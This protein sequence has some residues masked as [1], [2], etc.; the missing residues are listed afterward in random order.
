MSISEDGYGLASTMS[1]RHDLDDLSSFIETDLTLP[2]RPLER[3]GPVVDNQV[4]SNCDI[5]AYDGCDDLEDS[6]G[7]VETDLTFSC[8]PLEHLGPVDEDHIVSNCGIGAPYDR[9]GFANTASPLHDGLNFMQRLLQELRDPNLDCTPESL[10]EDSDSE[11][12][13]DD[14]LETSIPRPTRNWPLHRRNSLDSTSISGTDSDVS[15]DGSIYP[16]TP[17]SQVASSLVTASDVAEDNMSPSS[18]VRSKKEVLVIPPTSPNSPPP[19]PV[20]AFVRS[21]RDSLSSLHGPWVPWMSL[22]RLWGTSTVN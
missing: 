19:F 18:T 4:I 7:D 8:E 3:L 9:D 20:K 10:S 21:L 17:P 1:Y 14:S 11:Y 13:D 2:C 22:P 6:S 16:L 12:G 15:D 5:G